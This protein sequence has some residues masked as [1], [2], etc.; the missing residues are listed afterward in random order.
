MDTHSSVN[1][2]YVG[3]ALLG[4]QEATGQTLKNLYKGC[5]RI[6]ILQLCMDYSPDYHTTE[7]DTVYISASKSKAYYRVKQYYRKRIKKSDG[8]PQFTVVTNSG[9]RL[10]PSFASCILDILPR[11]IDKKTYDKIEQFKPDCILTLGE[12][13]ATDRMVL[14]LSQKYNIPVVLHIMDNLED[15]FCA[16]FWELRF[17]RNEYLSLNRKL[18]D[19]SIKNFAIGQKMADEYGKRHHQE[20]VP[21]MN[22]IDSL[23][24]CEI[25]KKDKLLLLFSGGL[26][27]G[28]ATSLQTVAEAIQ[29]TPELHD[30]VTMEVYSSPKH[31]AQYAVT[32][33]EKCKVCEYVPQNQIFENLGRADILLHVESFDE[34]EIEFFRY[35]MSTKIPEYLSVG[36]PILCYGPDDICTVSYIENKHVGISVDTPEKLISALK[37]LTDDSILRLEMGKRALEVAEKEHLQSNVVKA[38]ENLYMTVHEEWRKGIGNS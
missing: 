28:R 25:Q 6:N 19:R 38:V 33:K 11:R 15:S 13:I 37:R 3:F 10:F 16:S 34:R 29:K 20:F 8:A 9:E 35:S 23:H 31:I 5:K 32:L 22:C 21:A 7:Y 14:H 12:N 2:L 24:E 27:G 17:F 18:F 30:L 36:R 4:D 1:V 26:H